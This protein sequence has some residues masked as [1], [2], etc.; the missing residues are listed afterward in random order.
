[1]KK[2][3]RCKKHIDLAKQVADEA[4]ILL[5][6]KDNFLP[7][8]ITK[9][10]NICVVGPN[11]H[12][13]NMGDYAW[14]D[15]DGKEG[16]DLFE[17]LTEAVGDRGTVTYAEGCDWWSQDDSKIADAVKAVED[18]DVAVVAVGTRSY[19]LARRMDKPTSGEGFDLSSLEPSRQAASVA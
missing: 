14:V 2:V 12:F 19:Y 9:Y 8:D 16:I 3:V 13:A 6:N 4:V 15:C 10:P 17:G 1:M 18:A 11:G 5:E 7:L